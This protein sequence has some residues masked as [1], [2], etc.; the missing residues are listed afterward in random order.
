MRLFGKRLDSKAVGTA[1]PTALPCPLRA[2]FSDSIR[3]MSKLVSEAVRLPS[4]SSQAGF[5]GSRG[6]PN[7]DTIMIAF[8][9]CSRLALQFLQ[10][11]TVWPDFLNRSNTDDG[12]FLRTDKSATRAADRGQLRQAAGASAPKIRKLSGAAAK[13]IEPRFSALFG[14]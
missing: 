1:Q 14:F 2:V 7:P 9:Q 8:T 10:N 12:G 11:I 5:P 4:H 13:K 6:T 3:R